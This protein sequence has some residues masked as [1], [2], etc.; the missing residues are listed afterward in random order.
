MVLCV[1]VYKN[2]IFSKS[3]F[4]FKKIYE[5]FFPTTI[6]IAFFTLSGKKLKF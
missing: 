3:I 2:K 1:P 6:L 5:I 4:L